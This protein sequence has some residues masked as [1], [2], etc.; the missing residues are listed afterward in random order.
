MLKPRKVTKI[1]ATLAKIRN[2]M[3]EE[4]DIA[5]FAAF[6]AAGIL[7]AS[8]IPYSQIHCTGL[9]ASFFLLLSMTLLMSGR[10]NRLQLAIQWSGI[11]SAAFLT[12]I[13]C[14]CAA[15]VS[16]ISSLNLPS[17][18]E[19]FSVAACLRFKAAI[20]AVPFADP[21]SEALLTA[22]LTGDRSALSPQLKE[23]FRQSGAAHLLALSGMHLGIIYAMIS[24][25]L[26]VLGNQLI[27]KRI[28][29]LVILLFCGIYTLGTGAGESITRAF[30]FILLNES[31][32]L[33]HRKSRLKEIMMAA[34]I[35]QLTTDPSAIRS[36]SFQLSHAAMAGIAF[37]HPVLKG[38]WP[39]DGKGPMR[40]I[41]EAAS[42]TISCQLSTAPLAWIY[43]RS[44]PINFLITN[45]IAIPLT[46]LLIPLAI[47]TVCLHA[48][49]IC[50][51]FAIAATEFLISLLRASIETIAQL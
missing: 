11:F 34:L 26:S 36:V 16:D 35:I 22:F 21:D 49:G 38:F 44:F 41:W 28:R 23:A 47:V 30:L 1:I 4:R 33:T 17:A 3:T 32:H 48:A 14:W 51:D 5:G 2:E 10:F 8:F 13:C 7:T 19:K 18:I 31:A 39:E 9:S 27:I 50:P 6:F 37:I 43:F 45:L 40:K 29:S 42:L 12:G 15:S 20:A 25:A 24:K 46:S